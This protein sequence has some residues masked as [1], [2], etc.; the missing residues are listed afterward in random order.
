MSARAK[1]VQTTSGRLYGIEWWCEGCQ[2]THLV[3]VKQGVE[4]PKGWGWNESL[5]LPTLTPSVH[6]HPH[7]TYGDGETVATTPRC[8]TFVRAGRIQYLG[9]CTHHLAGHTVDLLPVEEWP[10]G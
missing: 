6:V 7:K 9:D 4:G 1:R 3:P 2:D 5:D 8:H 10:R